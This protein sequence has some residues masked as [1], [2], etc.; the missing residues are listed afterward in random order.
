VVEAR[1]FTIDEIESVITGPESLAEFVRDL[2]EH[3][4]PAEPI[5]ILGS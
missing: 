2:L 4:P 5:E 3:G 1:W